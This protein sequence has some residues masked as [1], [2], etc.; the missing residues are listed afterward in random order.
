MASGVIFVVFV[1]LFLVSIAIIL[2]G[3]LILTSV[4]PDRVE[5]KVLRNSQQNIVNQFRWTFPVQPVLAQRFAPTQYS[6]K[7]PVSQARYNR[8]R[9]RPSRSLNPY[10]F[11]TYVMPSA[12][13]VQ[14]LAQ[15]LMRLGQPRN[16]MAYE[17]L[18]FTLAFVQ[19]G[20]NYTHD[21]SPKT[22]EIVEYPKYPIETLAEQTG[23][24]EDQAIL[25]A[26]LFCISN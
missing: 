20:I 22:G 25:I 18:C 4:K 7:L 24:C 14:N 13:E 21:V 2:I 1:I 6:L 5:Q 19:Q 16:F 23:D 10:R 8:F 26:W 17:L 15:K 3:T 9:R 11:D 12:P